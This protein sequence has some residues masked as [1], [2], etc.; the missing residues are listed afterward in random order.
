MYLNIE[1][2]KC[3]VSKNCEKNGS[4]PLEYD[5]K[6]YYCKLV[7]GY[8][9]KPVDETILSEESL[10]K[11]KE[12]GPCLT[13]VEIPIVE[14]EILTYKAHKIFSEAVLHPREV[15]VPPADLNMIKW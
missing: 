3:Q 2:E 5:G 4:S 8:G 7:G 14:D 13:I 1:C 9:R 12:S 11:M 15:N 10:K 6:K